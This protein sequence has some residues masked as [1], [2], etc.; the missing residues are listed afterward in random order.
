VAAGPTFGSISCRLTALR[1]HVNGEPGLGAFQSK[2]AKSVDKAASNVG[3]GATLCGASNV[4]K[5]K[6][7]LQQGGKAL[8]QFVHRLRGNAARKQLGALPDAFVA[9]AQPIA[10]D[11]KAL[12]SAVQCPADAG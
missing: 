8:T 2:L 12:R 10:D 11:V 4:K 6:K 3:E 9:E 1:A 7:R 5:T